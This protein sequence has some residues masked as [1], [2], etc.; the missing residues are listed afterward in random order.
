MLD[1]VDMTGLILSRINPVFRI[2]RSVESCFLA[3]P[4]LLR[5]EQLRPKYLVYAV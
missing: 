3:S 2:R 1:G 5:D 4:C